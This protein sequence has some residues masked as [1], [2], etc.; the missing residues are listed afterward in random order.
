MWPSYAQVSGEINPWLQ[1]PPS[2]SWLFTGQGEGAVLCPCPPPTPDPHPGVPPE[3]VLAHCATD[4]HGLCFSLTNIFKRIFSLFLF[5]TLFE[6]LCLHIPLPCSLS[7]LFP[8]D[9]VESDFSLW[10]QPPPVMAEPESLSH[11]VL[12]PSQTDGDS[13]TTPCLPWNPRRP[14]PN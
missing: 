12:C 14:F 1:T 5:S 8:R 11:F 13:L 7:S 3:R 10:L 9:D 6:S 2:E 4:W